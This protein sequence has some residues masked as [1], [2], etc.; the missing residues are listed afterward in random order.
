MPRPHRC[1]VFR[2]TSGSLRQYGPRQPESQ[3]QM[4]LSV[5]LG[6]LTRDAL[7]LRHSLLSTAPTLLKAIGLWHPEMREEEI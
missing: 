2:Q 1:V 4:P 5:A 6:D 3:F 7:A